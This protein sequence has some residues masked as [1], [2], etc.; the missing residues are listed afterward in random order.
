MEEG[1]CI[2]R[3]KI[4]NGIRDC[5]GNIDEKDCRELNVNANYLIFSIN[6]KWSIIPW[7]Y[8]HYTLRWCSSYANQPLE[9]KCKITCVKYWIWSQHQYYVSTFKA[10]SEFQYKCK[11]SQCIHKDWLCDGTK[12]CPKGDDEEVASC[13]MFCF[14]VVSCSS[15]IKLAFFHVN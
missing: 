5:P 8:T 11:E 6:T 13:R 9:E 3:Y 10:C 2:P 4:C 14:F 1:V 12:D 15:F 7:N